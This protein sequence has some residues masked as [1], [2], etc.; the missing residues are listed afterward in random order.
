VRLLPAFVC[1]ILT[2]M[3]HAIRAS[4]K[5]GIDRPEQKCIHSEEPQ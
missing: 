3:L 2:D 5:A 4:K 1:K